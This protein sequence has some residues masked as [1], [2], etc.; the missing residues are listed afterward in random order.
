MLNN[1]KSNAKTYWSILK[2]NYD[3]KIPFTPPI[4]INDKLV[5]N[6]KTKVNHTNIFLLS[7]IPH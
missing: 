4:L 3:G 5:S 2:K 1:P 7:T 6:F